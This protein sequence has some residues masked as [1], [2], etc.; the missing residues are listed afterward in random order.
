M[1]LTAPTTNSRSRRESAT[2]SRPCQSSRT[3]G[4]VVTSGVTKATS[5]ALRAVEIVFLADPLKGFTKTCRKN[6]EA[7]FGIGIWAGATDVASDPGAASEAGDEAGWARAGAVAV[8]STPEAISPT[9]TSAAEAGMRER[10]ARAA[11]PPA[12]RSHRMRS[13]LVVE[14][15]PTAPESF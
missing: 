5:A 10:R 4:W 11:R 8:A 6:H 15:R 3:R 9:I 2:T 12:G 14:D 7:G 1:I 13:L